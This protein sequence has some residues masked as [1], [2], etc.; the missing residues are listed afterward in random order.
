[1]SNFFVYF[2]MINNSA[3]DISYSSYI[4][5]SSQVE[6][7]HSKNVVIPY[8]CKIN[9]T[10]KM[11]SFVIYKFLRFLFCHS[12]SNVILSLSFH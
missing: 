2:L 8:H 3:S 1:M 4:S 6:M 10:G 12:R 7:G 11:C 9:W 5:I